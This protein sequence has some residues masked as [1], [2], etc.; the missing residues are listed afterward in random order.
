MESRKKPCRLCLLKDIDP[1]EY[2]NR[3]KRVI[4]LMDRKDKA[5]N[6][7]YEDRLDVCRKCSYLKDAFC[8]ACGC[9]VELRAAGIKRTCPDTENRWG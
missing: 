7:E 1:K 5:S 6:D 4:D 8:G 9:Y 2:E 3:I